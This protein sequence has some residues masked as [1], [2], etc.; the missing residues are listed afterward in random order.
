MTV[1]ERI[2]CATVTRLGGAAKRLPIAQLG[3][4]YKG[5]Q[6][7]EITRSMLAEVV[8]NFRKLDTGEIPI[9][10]D[11]AIEFAAGNG[12]AVPAAGWIK[13]IEDAPDREGILWGTVDW[14]PKAAAMIRA[15]EY[16]YLSPVID[17]SVRDNRTGQPQGWSLTSA[18]LTNQPVLQ[19]MPALVLS[20]GGG[21]V[22]TAM[23]GRQVET[24]EASAQVEL[25]ERI[26]QTMAADSSLSYQ[27]AM[28][29]VCSADRDLWRRYNRRP[30]IQNA[31]SL[32]SQEGTMT[33]DANYVPPSGYL[34]QDWN[35][36]QLEVNS[37]VVALRN[38]NPL[39]GWQDAETTVFQNDPGLAQKILDVINVEIS[40]RVKLWQ[41]GEVSGRKLD[42]V[43]AFNTVMNDDPTLARQRQ[44]VSRV[45]AITKHS[46]PVDDTALM[47]VDS[48]INSAVREKIALSEGRMGYGDAYAYVLN[49]RPDLKRRKQ[50]AL[51][52]RA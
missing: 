7:I 25:C 29:K 35:P 43:A 17:P 22:G 20:A 4:R 11:H 34:N 21:A 1:Q 32:S 36:M 37:R 26:R 38:A 8:A 3:V 48:E 27:S 6:K 10:Y 12:E 19:G 24:T 44:A 18:A 16:K 15:K 39:L 47:D 14:T 42:Y 46:A 33:S 52:R 23:E 31:V 28:T 41:E 13:S 9:D 5:K 2:S 50:G 51:R 40:R 30:G 45:V 49:N